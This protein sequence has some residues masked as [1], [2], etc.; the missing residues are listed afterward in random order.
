LNDAIK[1]ETSSDS[2]RDPKLPSSIHFSGT[3][4]C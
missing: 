4:P 3:C 1:V 2:G